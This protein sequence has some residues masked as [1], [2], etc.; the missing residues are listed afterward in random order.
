MTGFALP[1]DDDLDLV[2]RE[3][4]TVAP[5]HAVV[6][7][8][9]GHLR[10]WEAWAQGEQTLEGAAACARYSLGEWAAGRAVPAALRYRGDVVGAVGARIDTY[11]GSADLGYWIDAAHQGG[12][13]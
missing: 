12:G 3:E 4:W 2:L 5:L 7:A 10:R 1:V 13:S 8:N 9:L 11:A 6:V